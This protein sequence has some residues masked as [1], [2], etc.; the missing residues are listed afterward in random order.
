M[1]AGYR[2]VQWVVFKKRYDLLLVSGIVLYLAAFFAAGKLVHAGSHAISDEILIARALGTCGFILLSLILCIGPAARLN[3]RFLPLLY[4]RRHLGVATFC[5][6]LLHALLGFGFYHGFG[7][8]S[9]AVSL[10]TSNTQFRSVS[11]FPFEILGLAALLILFLMAATSHDFWLKTLSPGVWKA[12]HMLVYPAWGLLVMHV[13]LG[14]LQSERN[15]VY[16][17]LLILVVTTV[18]TLHIAAGRYE[19]GRERMRAGEPWID[20]GPLEQIPQNRAKIVC[21]AGRER[22]AVFRYGESVSAVGNVCAHQGGPLGDGKII[23][24]CITC[25]W[26][27]FQYRPQDGCAPPPFT[28]QVPTY[29]VRVENGRVYVNSEPKESGCG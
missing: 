21:A 7:R 1:S 8:I 10:L 13:A 17:I 11:A 5:V 27:G 23:D 15:P 4:N 22:I 6:G 29:A 24:G 28:E 25:P 12:L 9:P 16:A 20:A 14:A 26:H 18:A 2:A 19:A 3:R